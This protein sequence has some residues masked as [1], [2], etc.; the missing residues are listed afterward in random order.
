MSYTTQHDLGTFCTEQFMLYLVRHV[1]YEEVKRGHLLKVTKKSTHYIYCFLWIPVM[2]GV[3]KVFKEGLSIFR[4]KPN[5]A[6]TI[7][8]FV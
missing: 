4:E 6:A 1:G 2:L 8:D 3:K 7:L 5:P